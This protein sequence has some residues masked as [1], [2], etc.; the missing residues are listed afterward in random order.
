MWILIVK[1]IQKK[2]KEMDEIIHKIFS[3][4]TVIVS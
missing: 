1:N 2:E 4:K 3:K